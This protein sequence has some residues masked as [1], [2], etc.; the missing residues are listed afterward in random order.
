MILK[1]ISSRGSFDEFRGS[2]G[3]LDTCDG[4]EDFYVAK[5]LIFYYLF[6]SFVG[7]LA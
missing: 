1:D 6:Y 4:H 3:S 7:S 5:G 2:S